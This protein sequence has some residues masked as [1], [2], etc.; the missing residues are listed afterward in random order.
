MNPLNDLTYIQQ[1]SFKD[2]RVCAWCGKHRNTVML[3]AKTFSVPTSY[4][5]NIWNIYQTPVKPVTKINEYIFCD[6]ACAKFFND[7]V[8]KIEPEFS[9]YRRAYIDGKLCSESK[10]IY[11]KCTKKDFQLLMNAK[12]EEGDK[13]LLKKIYVQNVN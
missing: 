11:E 8:E 4:N 7:N 2:N 5:Y 1:E 13:T 3:C 10:V 6:L 12:Y 9:S